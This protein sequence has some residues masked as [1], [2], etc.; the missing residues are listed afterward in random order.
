MRQTGQIIMFAII[1]FAY[2][3]I[4]PNTPEICDINNPLT[5]GSGTVSGQTEDMQSTLV[6]YAVL[7]S[8]LGIARMTE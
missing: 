7:N 4:G 6:S 8:S 5:I 3:F 2:I 1:M